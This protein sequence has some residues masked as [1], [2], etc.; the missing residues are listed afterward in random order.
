MKKTPYNRINVVF[1][2]PLTLVCESREE[3]DKFYISGCFVF[4]N[5]GIRVSRQT[6]LPKGCNIFFT[7]KSVEKQFNHYFC[8]QKR[9]RIPRWFSGKKI[10]SDMIGKLL[11]LICGW[12]MLAGIVSAQTDS[13]SVGQPSVAADTL[14]TDSVAVKRDSSSVVPTVRLQESRQVPDSV[15]ESRKNRNLL[16]WINKERVNTDDLSP[17]ARRILEVA[18]SAKDRYEDNGW[19]SDTIVVNPLFMPIVFKGDILPRNFRLYRPDSET[20]TP[21]YRLNVSCKWLEEGMMLDTLRE[22]AVYEVINEMPR[23]VKYDIYTLPELPESKTLDSDR[24]RE[25]VRVKKREQRKIGKLNMGLPKPEPWQTRMQSSLQFS[26]NYISDNWYQ[27]GVSNLNILNRQYL[28][29]AYNDLKKLQFNCEVEWKT[30]VNSTPDDSLH[31]VRVNDDLFRIDSSVGLKAAERWYYTFAFFF[32]TQFFNSYKA[33]SRERLT[34]FFSPGELNLGLGMNYEL[35]IDKRKF[36]TSVM[37]APLSYNL[38]FVADTVAVDPSSYEL[39]PGKRYAQEIGSSFTGKVTW[40]IVK[41]VS[42]NM[43]L[44]YYTNYNRVQVEWE[45]TFDFT[46]TRFLSTRIFCHLRYD[47]SQVPVSGHSYFQFRE[48]LSFG[49]NYRW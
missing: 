45:N 47:D 19:P 20:R 28:K 14:T 34:A 33:N 23:Y 22:R 1:N 18:L 9:K 12:G 30:G 37:L 26:Q 35:K 3:R 24:F 39:D 48:L 16:R 44:Y 7:E 6:G 13:L 36:V 5:E 43:R 41:Q 49:L 21:E 2:T 25:L 29:V 15:T 46:V 11:G 42:W 8:R 17:R 38:K 32:K 4:S 31:K 27:G 40:Q 10:R